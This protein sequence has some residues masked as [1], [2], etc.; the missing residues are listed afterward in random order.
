MSVEAVHWALKQ[1]T[2]EAVDKLILISLA[3][4]AGHDHTCFPSRKKLA[5]VGMCSLDTVDRAN[6][7]LEARGLIRKDRRLH[8]AGGLA[9]NCYVLCVDGVAANCGE[10]DA[11]D[12]RTERPGQPHDAARVTAQDCGEGSRMGCGHKEPLQE[13][14]QEP[15]TPLPPKGGPTP[16]DALK[17]F[18]AYNATALRC[19]L[20]Q[21]PK[22]T[23]DRQRKIIARLRDYGLEG[24]HKALANIERSSFLTGKNDNGWRASLEFMLQASSFAKLHDGAYGNG[25][26]A[27]PKKSDREPTPIYMLPTR[28]RERTEDELMAIAIEQLKADGIAV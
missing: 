4:Y 25:R 13:P 6:K 28:R 16:L 23:P 5:E 15:R 14:P 19:G 24:W 17:A 20:P 9:S 10:D 1:K 12:S 8:E 2:D 11:E 26:H 7:R 18:E 27:E 22:F 3:D 21:A